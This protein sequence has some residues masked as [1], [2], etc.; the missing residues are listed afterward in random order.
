MEK[1]RIQKY[2]SDCGIMSRRAAE[3]EIES[4]NVKVNGN[5]AKLGDKIDP[6]LD[7]V[8]YKGT[9][10]RPS[11]ST[12]K[13]YIMLNKPRGYLSSVSD[14]RGRKCVTELVAD[15]GVRVYPVGRL[16]MDSEG[17]L[18]LTDDGELTFKLT[19]PKHE[20]P[21]I[22]NVTLSGEISDERLGRLHNPIEIDGRQTAPIKLKV[23]SKKDNKTIIE[24][25]LYEGRNR[26]IRRMC[27]AAELKL[28]RLFRVA[29]GDLKLDVPSG[30][31]RFLTQPE[32]DYLY[33]KSKL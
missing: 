12:E 20:F 5:V 13:T 21:K 11:R 19:H 9:I 32:I 17:F 27:E 2:F 24:I 3:S 15:A 26:Q 7:T 28:T 22:Y 25:T 18:L 23:V 16:D 4:G 14:D 29:V 33:G 10:I 6:S 1:I 31:W 8:E 30:K